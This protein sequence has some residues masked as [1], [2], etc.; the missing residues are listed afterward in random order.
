MGCLG[1]LGRHELGHALDHDLGP[2]LAGT[3]G[4]GIGHLLDVP[5]GRIIQNQNLGHVNSDMV[6][7]RTIRSGLGC[8]E[9]EDHR[10]PLLDIQEDKLSL[11]QNQW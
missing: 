8:L 3:F 5:P 4:G 6:G 10:L 7:C 1:D 2:G 9:P 11:L